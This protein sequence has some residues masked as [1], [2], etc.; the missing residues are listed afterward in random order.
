MAA[1][2]NTCM[3]VIINRCPA[4]TGNQAISPGPLFK[5]SLVTVDTPEALFGGFRKVK[6]S[7]DQMVSYATF[8]EISQTASC[9]FLSKHQCVNDLLIIPRHD[10]E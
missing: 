3:A 10:G 2:S 8:K 1:L 6:C 9:D 4:T 7:C 5:T